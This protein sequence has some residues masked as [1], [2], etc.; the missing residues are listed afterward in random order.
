MVAQGGSSSRSTAGTRL[1]M[2]KHR[3]YEKVSASEVKGRLLDLKWIDTDK[4]KVAETRQSKS[5]GPA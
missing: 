4:I 5:C 2:K 3:I 1:Y